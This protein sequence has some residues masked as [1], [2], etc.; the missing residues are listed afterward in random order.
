MKT[1]HHPCV[2]GRFPLP[3]V[4][5]PTG[6]IFEGCL[7]LGRGQN[8]RLNYLPASPADECASLFVSHLAISCKRF[9]RLPKG[10]THVLRFLLSPSWGKEMPLCVGLIQENCSVVSPVVWL[11]EGKKENQQKQKIS[12]KK[13][14]EKKPASNPL[15]NSSFQNISLLFSCAALTVITQLPS[16]HPRTVKSSSL[17]ELSPPQKY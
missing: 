9:S 12:K 14:Q 15:C 3:P 1:Q 16:T 8:P 2:G 6:C 17:N 13:P 4:S 7:W 10:S 5:L 11:H